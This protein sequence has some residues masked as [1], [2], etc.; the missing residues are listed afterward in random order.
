MES[1]CNKR[2]SQT[3]RRVVLRYAINAFGQ[4]LET[5]VE[6]P[7]YEEFIN[8]TRSENLYKRRFRITMG[9]LLENTASEITNCM[10]AYA[11]EKRNENRNT[12]NKITKKL[13]KEESKKDKYKGE[14]QIINRNVERIRK[15][16]N[17]TIE[18]IAE[19]EN[20]QKGVFNKIHGE[21]PYPGFGVISKAKASQKYIP[22]LKVGGGDGDLEEITITDRDVVEKMMRWDY[23]NLYRNYDSELNTNGLDDFLEGAQVPKISEEHKNSLEREITIEEL[24]AVLKKRKLSRHPALLD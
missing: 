8:N 4:N 24:T 23:K 10:I 12:I 13:E 5:D 17:E 3:F 18:K 20:V 19:K 15:E 9:E 16:L 21:Q 11:T 7:F 14:N 22:A 1:D 2:L 6:G